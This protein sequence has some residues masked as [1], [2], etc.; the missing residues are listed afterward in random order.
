LIARRPPV[1]TSCG[2]SFQLFGASL[3]PG[4]ALEKAN[5]SKSPFD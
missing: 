2:T 4:V 5:E 3:D 1:G